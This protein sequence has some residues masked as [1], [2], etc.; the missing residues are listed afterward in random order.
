MILIGCCRFGEESHPGE[1]M[2]LQSSTQETVE[3]DDCRAG[4]DVNENNTKPMKRETH[5]R[6]LLVTLPEDDFEEEIN[7]DCLDPVEELDVTN[8]LMNKTS[9]NIEV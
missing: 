4:N 3:N 9:L 7:R 6:N 2:L 1:I 8:S 5:R